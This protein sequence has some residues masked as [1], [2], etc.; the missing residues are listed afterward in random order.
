[1]LV[2]ATRNAKKRQELAALLEGTGLA[3]CGPEACPGAPAEVEE[4]GTTFRENALL[5]ARAIAGACGVWA[6]ADDSGL[7]VEALGGEPGVRSARFAGPGADDDANNRLLLQRLE[8][9]PL[10]RRRARF[11]S[12]IALV[13]P[14]GE[15]WTW[16]G[17]CEGHIALEPR[18]SGGFGYDPLFVPDGYHITFGEMDPAL[19]NQISHRARALAAAAADLRRLAPR[20]KGEGQGGR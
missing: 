13:S 20:M 7:E 15:E 10:H 16:E 3:V 1:M 17:T 4:T 18:G 14:E 19:K 6:I 9:V 5:K 8:G 12:V 2:M 11:V